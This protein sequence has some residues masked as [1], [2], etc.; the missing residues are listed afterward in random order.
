MTV[1]EAHAT[2]ARQSSVAGYFSAN[3]TSWQ[4]RYRR[5]ADF[6]AHNYRARGDIA[7]RWLDELHAAGKRDLLE[8]GCGAG[9]QSGR[10]A[11]RGWNVAAVD[12]AVDMLRQAA[13]ASRVPS[14]A[15]ATVESLPFRP[16]SFDAVMMLGVIG[17]VPNPAEALAR[18]REQLRPAGSLIISWASSPPMLLDSVSARVSAIPDRLY[19]SLR[20]LIDPTWAPWAPPEETSFFEQHNRFWT[21]SDFTAVLEQNG[22]TV[23]RCRAVNF[24]KLRFMGHAAWPEHVDIALSRVL[25]R[26]TA[27][28]PLS[29]LRRHARTHVALAIPR[30]LER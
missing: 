9:V 7:L 4:E 3:A 10:A 25:E 2:D 23:K 28:R 21:E 1:G 22:F 16:G 20:R 11:V 18:V 12:I 14:W 27:R 5:D 15:A 26:A 30:R 29:P 13:Q 24:G 17:Y 19:S 6:D 8:L